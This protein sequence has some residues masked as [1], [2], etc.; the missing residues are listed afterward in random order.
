MGRLRSAIQSHPLQPPLEGGGVKK[1][2][3]LNGESK[4][5]AY[6]PQGEGLPLSFCILQSGFHN[7]S[8]CHAPFDPALP[9]GSGRGTC[10]SKV[11]SLSLGGEG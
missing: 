6:A 2:S 4:A 7:F 3:I 9:D 11:I 10:G 1:G 5:S 8:D